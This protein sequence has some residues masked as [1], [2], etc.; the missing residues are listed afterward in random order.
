MLLK[1]HFHLPLS[2]R[3]HWHSFHNA[4]ATY[5]SAELNRHLPEKYFA[6][7]NV[8]FG[9]EIGV[10]TLEES[11][12]EVANGAPIASLGSSAPGLLSNEPTVQP[13]WRPSVPVQIAPFHFNT[14]TIEVEIYTSDEGPL[15]VG[16]IEIVSPANKDRPHNRNAFVAK[17]ETYLRRG[18]GLVIVDIVTNRLTNLHNALLDQMGLTW[19]DYLDTQL[20]A[21]AYRPHQTDEGEV[22]EIWTEALAV[23]QSLPTV[24]LWLRDGPCLP[25]DLAITYERT[26]EEQ[27]IR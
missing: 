26:C 20:Y 22:L 17:C 8:Q 18:I 11:T 1:D 16:A 10:A 6:E 13:V 23:E 7:P 25:I 24:P 5:I 15:L 12:L 2:Q 21:T 14:D 27:R 4:W 19:L 3:R 9:I